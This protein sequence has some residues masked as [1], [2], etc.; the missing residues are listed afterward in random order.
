MSLR[1]YVGFGVLLMFFS[2]FSPK[3]SFNDYT[4]DM[5]S[6][7]YGGG[8]SGEYKEFSLLETGDLYKYSTLTKEREYLGIVEKNL[9]DQSFNNYIVLGLDK[10]N[11]NNSGNMNHY[12][13][14]KDKNGENK[15]QWSDMKKI[16]SDLSLYYK[17]LMNSFKK[18][19]KK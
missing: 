17:V 19:I 10:M 18:F 15:L 2:C 3:Q 11:V 4:G 13:I 16:D 1:Y 9:T 12:I 8:F 6:L 14:Y 5:I 7:G